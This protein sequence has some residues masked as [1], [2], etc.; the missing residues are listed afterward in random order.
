MMPTGTQAPAA[1]VCACCG[2]PL[3]AATNHVR[4][5]TLFGASL[6]AFV[7]F[8]GVMATIIW[9]IHTWKVI[10]DPPTVAQMLIALMLAGVALGAGLGVD[11]SPILIALRRILPLAPK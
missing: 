8:T 1:P 9:N 10:W 5:Y 4:N 7:V 2:Q 11:L 3:P 6:S